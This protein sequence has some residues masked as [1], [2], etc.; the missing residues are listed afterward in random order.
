MPINTPS[1]FR[2][3]EIVREIDGQIH[4][5]S[6]SEVSKLS[7]K[8]ASAWLCKFVRWG[9]LK[10]IGPSELGGKSIQ[11]DIT[12]YGSSVVHPKKKREFKRRGGFREVKK[13][14]ANPKKGE[15]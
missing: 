13:I 14:A 9:Y 4:S 10:K 3:L 5:S 15:E 8:D 1:W 11:Y 7:P 2:I 6:L 12:E